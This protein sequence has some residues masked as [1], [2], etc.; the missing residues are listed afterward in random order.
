MYIAYR[1]SIIAAQLPGRT[2]NDIKNY[3]NT[4]LKKKLMMGMVSSSSTTNTTHY[5]PQAEIV[6]TIE[7]LSPKPHQNPSFDYQPLSNNSYEPLGSA[8]YSIPLFNYCNNP[9]SS[10]L[11]TNPFDQNNSFY[12]TLKPNQVGFE[13]D[14]LEYGGLNSVSF[15][16]GLLFDEK[17]KM[18]QQNNNGNEGYNG[19]YVEGNA[20][21]KEE[22]EMMEQ[23]REEEAKR[24]TK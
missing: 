18:M 12:E 10:C 4:K 14:E 3:W 24:S 5:A 6:K 9:I 7:T 13:F 2:D 22:E 16:N 23:K 11:V 8:N 20:M 15:N 17:M 19:N 21:M 1:W